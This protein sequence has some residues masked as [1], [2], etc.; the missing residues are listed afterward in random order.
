MAPCSVH[1]TIAGVTV[2]AHSR[3]NQRV[4]YGHNGPRPTTCVAPYG[5]CQRA[6]RRHS[7]SCFG[8]IRLRRNPPITR[9]SAFARM[10]A[11]PP[12]LRFMAASGASTYSRLSRVV[13]SP[14]RRVI[15]EDA[16]DDRCGSC[17]TSI[18]P[19]SGA[20]AANRPCAPSTSDS[21]FSSCHMPTRVGLRPE[22]RSSSRRPRTISAVSRALTSGLDIIRSGRIPS[23]VIPDAI[24]S[25]SFLPDSVSLRFASLEMLDERSSALPCLRM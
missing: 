23:A 9:A 25:I 20:I 14:E 15:M 1:F 19:K 8:V 21:G 7:L 6:A 4:I 18:T 13:V 12:F 2:A 17:P 5:R 22:S 24:C 3:K 10:I 11:S 16:S